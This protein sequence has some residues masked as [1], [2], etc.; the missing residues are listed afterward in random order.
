ME[1]RKY[2]VKHNYRFNLDSMRISM[3][4]IRDDMRDGVITEP[5]EVMGELMTEDAVEAFIAEIEDLIYKAYG[6]VTG[7]EYGRIKAI[8]DARNAMRYATCIAAG[9]SE[10]DAALAFYE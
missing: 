5:V 10:Y 9:M 3:L 2:Y 8:S 1:S 7:K 4:N 6:Q